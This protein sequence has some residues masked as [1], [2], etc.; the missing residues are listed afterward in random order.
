MSDG[1]E[2][3]IGLGSLHL[4]SLGAGAIAAKSFPCASDGM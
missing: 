3:L 1:C 4:I 2:D